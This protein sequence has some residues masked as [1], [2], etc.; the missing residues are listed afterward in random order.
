MRNFYLKELHFG[1]Y[2]KFKFEPQIFKPSTPDYITPGSGLNII[3]GSI[4]SGKTSLME[5]IG[6]VHGQGMFDRD[7]LAI[8]DSEAGRLPTVKAVHVSPGHEDTPEVQY[9]QR[10]EFNWNGRKVQESYANDFAHLSQEDQPSGSSMKYIRANRSFTGQ[11]SDSYSNTILEAIDIE[12]RTETINLAAVAQ[13]IVNGS[14]PGGPSIDAFR[15]KLQSFS[16]IGLEIEDVRITEPHRSG[17]PI[18]DFEAKVV[19]GEWHNVQDLSDGTKELLCWIYELNFGELS[20]C[21]TVCIDEIERSLHPQIQVALMEVIRD[22]STHQQFFITTHS[23]HVADP[24]TAASIHRITSDGQLCSVPS[25]DFPPLS[26]F[27]IDHRRAFFTD[28]VLFVEGVDDQSFYIEKLVDY[29]YKDLVT[30]V[31]TLGGKGNTERFEKIMRDLNIKFSAIVDDDFSDR[32]GRL[33]SDKRRFLEKT[34]KELD[35]LGKLSGQ[36]D[37][38]GLDANLASPNTVPRARNASNVSGRH[39]RKVVDKNIY[40]LKF[41]RLEEYKSGIDRLGQDVRTEQEAELRDIFAAIKDA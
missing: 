36:V 16:H 40:P 15:N 38:E 31:F 23:L 9:E 8:N 14:G 7:R 2:R 29:G 11:S 30:K 17:Q 6:L 12:S 25:E 5:I 13:A 41:G 21:R 33:N 28:E 26:I 19:N 22:R 3:V 4:G 35:N 20:N 10:I 39:F 32:I 27:S 18:R 1:G 24:H 37:I 34:L